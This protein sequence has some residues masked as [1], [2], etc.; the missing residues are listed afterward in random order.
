[1]SVAFDFL[2][3]LENREKNKEKRIENLTMVK[4]S[5]FLFLIQFLNISKLSNLVTF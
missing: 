5:G 1:L 3:I 4:S 2:I